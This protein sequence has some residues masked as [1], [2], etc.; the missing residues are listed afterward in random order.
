MLKF[1]K[2]KAR[3]RLM[4]LGY[5]PALMELELSAIANIHPDLQAVFDAWLSG[6]DLDF[7][8]KGISLSKIKEKECCDQINALSTMS[9]LI[10]DPSSIG[11]FESVS[12]D[13]FRRKCGGHRMGAA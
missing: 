8:F 3:Q 11:L 5:S 10:N 7:E 1:S 13:L 4:A 12:A 6:Q 9:M 2:E